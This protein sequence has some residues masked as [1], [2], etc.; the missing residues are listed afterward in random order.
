[1]VEFLAYRIIEGKFNIENVPNILKEDVEK[2]LNEL[3][4]V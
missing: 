2:K 1:M 3:K 4:G